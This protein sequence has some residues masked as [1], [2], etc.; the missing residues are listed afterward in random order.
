MFWV[1]IENP[2]TITASGFQFLPNYELKLIFN[3]YGY[4]QGE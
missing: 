4:G 3:I 1:E 2:L